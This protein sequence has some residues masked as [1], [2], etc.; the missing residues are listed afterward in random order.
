[1]K[2][3]YMVS[4]D[5]ERLFTNI[6]LDER[7]DLAD[8]YINKGNPGFKLSASDLKRLFSFATTETHFLFKGTFYDQIDGVAMGS[9]LVAVL[10]NIFMGHHEKLWLEQYKDSVALFYRRYV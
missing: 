2:G 8:N 7:I 9:P 1:M 6:P 3:N 4:F 10:A 5:V